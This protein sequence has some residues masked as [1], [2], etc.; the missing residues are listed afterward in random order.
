MHGDFN[1]RIGVE[2]D[3][4]GYEK[5]DVELGIQNLDNQRGRNSENEKINSH[6]KDICKVNDLQQQHGSQM[7]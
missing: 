5:S 4:V 7:K 6:G 2:Q 1:G 3:F